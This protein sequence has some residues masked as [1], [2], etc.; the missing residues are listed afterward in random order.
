MR[1]A[2]VL[3]VAAAVFGSSALAG[4]TAVP[5]PLVGTWRIG[6]SSS[7]IIKANGHAVFHFGAEVIPESV[8]G[9]RTRLTFSPA[10]SCAGKGT[11]S[12]KLSGRKLT[13][14]PVHDACVIRSASLN[15]TWTRK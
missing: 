5:R 10:G 2:V 8:S 13:L 11:Y 9:T 7:I 12:W 4:T 3:V 6:T 14:R 15:G 1:G